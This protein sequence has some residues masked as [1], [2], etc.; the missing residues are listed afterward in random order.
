[1]SKNSL[2]VFFDT[3]FSTLGDKINLPRLISI[4]CVAN[5]GREFYA[6]L[7]DTWQ[8]EYCSE[9][10]IETVLPLLQG[11]E[12]CMTEATLAERLKSWIEGFV[13]EVVFRTDSPSHDWPFV[14]EL[15]KLYGW[16]LNL[17]K[18]Y[19][20]VFFESDR[21]R[22]RYNSAIE[23]YFKTHGQRQHHALVDASS[24]RYAWKYAVKKGT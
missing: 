13:D 3:E 23:D 14:E 9:F 18:K 20:T 19:G 5:D 11:G 16:P 7:T 21:Q 6:E 1:M 10:V 17:R 22:H 8:K 4:G 15:F 24:M 12:F 2:S